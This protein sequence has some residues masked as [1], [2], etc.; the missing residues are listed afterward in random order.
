M[1]DHQALGGKYFLVPL[2][3]AD[4]LTQPVRLREGVV[5]EQHH[6]LA[7][8]QLN[9]LIDRM[10]KAGVLPVFDQ[11]KIVPRA[12]APRLLQAFVCG[13]V[14]HDDKLK[15]LLRLGIDRL[16]G[17]SKPALSVDVGDH[18]GRFHGKN[19]SLID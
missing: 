10:G 3:G 5:V 18:N 16:N 17:V 8:C 4:E 15:V 7:L 2:H 19:S 6:I 12:I 14:I 9:A 1:A 13:A 11:C